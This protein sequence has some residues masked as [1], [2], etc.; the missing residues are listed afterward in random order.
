M[1]GIQ[2]KLAVDGAGRITDV[3]TGYAAGLQDPPNLLPDGIEF[4]VH[5]LKSLGSVPFV[6]GGADRRILVAEHRIPHFYHGVG[7]GCDD[8]INRVGR[9]GLHLFGILKINLM[10]CDHKNFTRSDK[11]WSNGVVEHWSTGELDVFSAPI[12]PIRQHA[13]LVRIRNSVNLIKL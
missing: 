3:N 2:L 6:Q 8:Q 12:T 5:H 4:P 13:K 1:I 9:K 7:G 11:S 10:V